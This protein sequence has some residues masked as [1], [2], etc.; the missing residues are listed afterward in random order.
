MSFNLLDLK[1]FYRPPMDDIIHDF[2]V[3]V[4]SESVQYD[5]AVAFFSSS[6]L[7]DMTIGIQRMVSKGGHIRYIIS[8]E[9][10]SDE[11]IDAIHYGYDEREKLII[12]KM[13][14]V[15][16]NPANHFEEERLNLLAHLIETEVLDIKIAF[17]K[18]NSISGRGIFHDKTGI[19][20][21]EIGNK[22][23]FLGSYNETH[24]AE[25]LNNEYV[26][27]FSSLNGDYHR[28]IQMQDDFDQL[29]EDNY[30]YA[31]VIPFPE[32]LKKVIL[33]HEKPTLDDDI[34]LVEFPP[35]HEAELTSISVHPA[36]PAHVTLYD[37]Q[38]TAVKNWLDNS[39]RGIISLCTGAGKTY[40]ALEAITELIKTNKVVIIICC[41]YQHLVDQWCADLSDWHIDYIPGYS[42]APVRQWK[43][44]LGLEIND[45]N[46]NV[47]DYLCFITTNATFKTPHIQSEIRRIKKDKLLIVDEAH[48]FGATGLRRLLIDDLY[49][50]RM[51]L[52][53][54]IDRYND[55]EGT[56]A[57]Y[58][59]F[60]KKCI[61]YTLKD[62]IANHQLTPY[63]YYPIPVSLTPEELESYYELTD[64]IRKEV[65]ID[66]DGKTKKITELGKRLLIKRAR[67][68]A[69][70]R[71]KLVELEKLMRKETE[72]KHIL[73]YCGATTV[74]DPD[75]KENSSDNEEEK[76]ITAVADILNKKLGMI[77]C[78]FTATENAETRRKLIQMFDDGTA[79]QVLVAIKCLDEGVS[80]KSIEKAYILASSTNPREYIQRRGRVLRKYPGKEFAYIYD[81]V[82][83]PKPLDNIE[84]EDIDSRDL[85]LIR[86]EL[87]RVVDFSELSEKSSSSDE[88]I[89]KIKD[90][91]GPIFNNLG[92]I[93][94]E[95][96]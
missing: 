23:S 51:A 77:A 1:L 22:I 34:D 87:A 72:S 49:K 50:Y 17:P 28:V 86:R 84:I 13:L 8:P 7:Y 19:M 60:G 10:L 59:F 33:A 65:R 44:K 68:V 63:Y 61:E 16:D 95:P 27:V 76:Q 54:T 42:G 24:A 67:L 81:F 29:W 90:I 66:S 11:D 55:A 48:N 79:C 91:Y 88:F 92:E 38:K 52:S 94:D 58:N 37:Y 47:T 57:L 41:P 26:T 35:K 20:T 85:S 31:E 83:L 21:D 96:E 18:N 43:K 14:P 4:L 89:N 46:R 80:I 75:F 36:K 9:N 93:E 12:E 40:V 73:V 15:F 6:V 56:A 25:C 2:F 53:A 3:P 71:N 64:Q 5:R 39:G 70:A 32:D 45:F 30:Q 74:N 82:T 69:G 62:G 78:K